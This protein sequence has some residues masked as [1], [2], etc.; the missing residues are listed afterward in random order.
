M[1][2]PV[3]TY[4]IFGGLPVYIGTIEGTR[5]HIALAHR[6]GSLLWLLL[7]SHNL[8]SVHVS[9]YTQNRELF[10]LS[11]SPGSSIPWRRASPLKRARDMPTCR[12]KRRRKR[13]G[14]AK[15]GR[16]HRLHRY[17]WEFIAALQ[18]ICVRNDRCTLTEHGCSLN[19]RIDCTTRT[20]SNTKQQ[21][22]GPFD[23]LK[24]IFELAWLISLFLSLIESTAQRR[25]ADP[26]R[27]SRLCYPCLLW[28][29]PRHIWDD[30]LHS[31]KKLAKRAP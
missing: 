7:K 9:E 16:T 23:L 25:C 12:S 5:P 29:R 19:E 24:A 6:A 17:R 20:S 22:L 3:H 27:P 8:S 1:Y 15:D 26:V 13:E 21:Y 10:K 30:A 28:H 18:Q 4:H 11:Q 14:T 2:L 31:H